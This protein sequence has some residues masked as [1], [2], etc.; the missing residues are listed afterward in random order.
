[1][2]A[3]VELLISTKKLI[4]DWDASKMV[5]L[6][7]NAIVKLNVKTINNLISFL[8]SFLNRLASLRILRNLY[9]L[10]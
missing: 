3:E 5:C 1:M 10:T 6:Q 7:V 9:L 2:L 8:C 4:K